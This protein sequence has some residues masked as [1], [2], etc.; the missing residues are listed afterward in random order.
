MADA[1][2]ALLAAERDA[3][4]RTLEECESHLRAAEGA[5]RLERRLRQESEHRLAEE[6]AAREA[7]ERELAALREQRL[8]G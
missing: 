7:A 6:R 8:A 4:R 1:L 5:A 2:S 3:T